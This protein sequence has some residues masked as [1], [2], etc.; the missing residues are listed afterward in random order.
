MISF[1]KWM[2]RTGAAVFTASVPLFGFA[3][4][5]GLFATLSGLKTLLDFAAWTAVSGVGLQLLG[6]TL[7]L[8]GAF[9]EMTAR[10]WEEEDAR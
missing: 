3:G 7:W 8:W 1:S 10:G 9:L 5:F 6:A 4:V 2:R